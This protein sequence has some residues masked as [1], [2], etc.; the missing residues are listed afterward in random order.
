MIFFASFF[1]PL[2]S[3]FFLFPSVCLFDGV[4]G[5]LIYRMYD[6]ISFFD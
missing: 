1:F 4:G 3:F 6:S 5:G 2:P